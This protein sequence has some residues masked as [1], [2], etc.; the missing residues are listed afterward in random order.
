MT[1]MAHTCLSTAAAHTVHKG[2]R[3]CGP[4]PIKE[5]TASD[6]LCI[7]LS[8]PTV[9]LAFVRKRCGTTAIYYGRHDTVASGSRS[10]VGPLLLSSAPNRCGLAHAEYH[11]VCG[12][13]ALAY[14]DTFG[15]ISPLTSLAMP[16]RR[17]FESGTA[18]DLGWSYCAALLFQTVWPNT[19]LPSAKT[20]AAFDAADGT[21][22]IA[23]H[24]CASALLQ[25]AQLNSAGQ[26]TLENEAFTWLD[27]V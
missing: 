15:T 8:G 19:G 21:G 25:A 14:Y 2:V 24:A 26:S 1:P 22:C 10:W 13:L 5:H 7:R 20:L 23:Y 27:R 12:T 6:A 17:Y 3:Y 18:H 11:P 4:M 9:A 16:G